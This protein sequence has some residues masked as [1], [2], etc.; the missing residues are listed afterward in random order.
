MRRPEARRAVAHFLLAA[1][2]DLAD[3]VASGAEVA[4]ALDARRVGAGPALYEYR[5]LYRAYVDA[6]VGRLARLADYA[7]AV[8]V[9]AADPSVAAAARDHAPHAERDADAIREAIL[10][11]LVVAVAEGAGG[12]E[13]DDAVFDAAF[14]R[15]LVDVAQARRAFTAFAPLTGVHAPDQTLDLGHGVIALRR[16]PLELAEA[17]PECQGLLPDAFTTSRDRLLGLELDVAMERGSRAE[18]PDAARRFARAVTA[19][20]LVFGGAIA[21]GPCLFE[22][23]DWSPRAVTALPASVT[24]APVSAATAI[25]PQRVSLVRALVERLADAEVRGG[26]VAVAIARWMQARSAIVAAERAA[27][28]VD[29]L[30]PLLG[31]DHAGGYAV[32]MRAAGLVGAS[33][34]ERER[35]AVALR[36]AQRLVRPDA[37]LCDV[38]RVADSVDEA[39]RCV[40]CAALDQ[41]DDALT[42]A[43][44]LDSVLLGARPR[45]QIISRLAR[46]A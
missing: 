6:R 16:T 19:L 2:R 28:M 21:A 35:V 34:S 33:A 43:E 14:D 3:D 12:F 39:V 1:L 18:D 22:R 45:P 27:G 4:F 11:P 31:S 41:Q 13:W 23:V 37:P 20:R 5:L 44:M 30:E 42:L 7:E 29:A 17:W 24:I 15:M 26:A 25:E 32:A 36:Q 40:L 9:L 8:R 38:E 46:I 10:V